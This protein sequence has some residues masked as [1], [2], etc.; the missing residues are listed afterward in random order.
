MRPYKWMPIY[1]HLPIFSPVTLPECFGDIL[2]PPKYSLRT[3]KIINNFTWKD[4]QFKAIWRG[5][6]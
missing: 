3:K 6:T 1:E 4:R 5:S 2:I